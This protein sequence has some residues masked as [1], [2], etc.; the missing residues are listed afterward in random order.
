MSL[1]NEGISCVRCKSYLFE[2]D[3][4]VTVPFAEHPITENV[5]TLWDIVLWKNFTA[6]RMNTAVKGMK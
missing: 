4:V 3:D 1:N 5:I 6:P 2:E